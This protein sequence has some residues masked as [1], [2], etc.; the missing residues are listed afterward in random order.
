MELIE[1]CISLQ[2]LMA[3]DEVWIT[4]SLRGVIPVTAVD[5]QPIHANVIGEKYLPIIKKNLETPGS[6]KTL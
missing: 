1:E 4:S 3:A 5:G 6:R 2:R